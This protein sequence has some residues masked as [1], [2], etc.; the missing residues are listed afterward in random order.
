MAS[1]KHSLQHHAH[2][3]PH[4]RLL[5]TCIPCRHILRIFW[6]GSVRSS[7]QKARSRAIQQSHRPYSWPDSCSWP[8]PAVRLV[9]PQQAPTQT[10]SR[11]ETS[12]F[13]APEQPRRTIIFTTIIRQ[14]RTQSMPTDAQQPSFC[15]QTSETF[16]NVMLEALS[17]VHHQPICMQSLCSPTPNKPTCEAPGLLPAPAWLSC[18]G[19]LASVLIHWI[20]HLHSGA[21][22]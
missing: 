6:A 1:L 16:Y 2:P 15:N 11:G 19:L 18:P 7:T 5:L 13:T 3:R 20:R 21:C 9:H 17:R 14:Q 22:C 8:G 12:N 10:V 4:C